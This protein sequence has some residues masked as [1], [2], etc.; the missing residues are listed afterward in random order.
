MGCRRCV[1]AVSAAVSDVPGVR[2]VEVDVAHRTVR[3]TGDANPVLVYAAVERA[4][5][6]AVT[7]PGS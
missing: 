4:G 5:F 2:T 6:G 3:V 7:G 1:R